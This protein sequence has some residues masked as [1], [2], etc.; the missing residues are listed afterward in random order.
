MADR[1]FNR[2]R[3]RYPGAPP[4]HWRRVATGGA[5][6]GAPCPRRGRDAPCS[7][8]RRFGIGRCVDC[9][10]NSTTGGRRAKPYAGSRIG[11]LI[12]EG[13]VDAGADIGILA[14]PVH[15]ERVEI[16]LALIASALLRKPIKEFAPWMIDEPA[17]M[18]VQDAAKSLIGFMQKAKR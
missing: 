6:L 14:R 15:A 18:S 17:K 1:P 3:A 11:R 7:A 9:G 13:L 5:P 10:G 12:G 2:T 8:E 4:E 16:L